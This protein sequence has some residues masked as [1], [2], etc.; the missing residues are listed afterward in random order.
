MKARVLA[1]LQNEYTESRRL[2]H[3][4]YHS[5]WDS[6]LS[7]YGMNSFE[8]VMSF[9]REHRIITDDT[10]LGAQGRVATL[11]VLCRKMQSLIAEDGDRLV[12][13][14]A[15]VTPPGAGSGTATRRRPRARAVVRGRHSAP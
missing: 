1:N 4:W 2:K 5:I 10:A 11:N 3:H 8:E 7:E 14:L 15:H 9:V 12:P 6:I 13:A